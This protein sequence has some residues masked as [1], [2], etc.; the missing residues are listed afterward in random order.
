MSRL[1]HIHINLIGERF[2]SMEPKQEEPPIVFPDG[3]IS[4]DHSTITLTKCSSFIDIHIHHQPGFFYEVF[5]RDG[6]L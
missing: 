4:L 2:V 6:G 1:I 5:L 3:S